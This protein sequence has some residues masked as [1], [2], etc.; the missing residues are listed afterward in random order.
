[1]A[2]AAFKAA[3]L[4][5]VCTAC[6]TVAADARTF[7]GTNWRVTA[8]DGR[9]TPTSGNYSMSFAGGDLAARFGCNSIGGRYSVSGD[10]L[11]ASEVRSTLMGCPEPAGRFE[12]EGLAVLNQSMR[13]TWTGG[14]SLTLSSGTGSI[15]LQPQP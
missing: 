14:G 6:T 5:L 13:M 11:T 1:M 8:I 3:V 7:E 2:A 4:A 12:R 10:T 9:A 15:A